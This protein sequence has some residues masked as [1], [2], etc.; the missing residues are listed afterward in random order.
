MIPREEARVKFT[1]VFKLRLSN[2]ND[3]AW[4]GA[5]NVCRHDL[6]PQLLLQKGQFLFFLKYAVL[7]RKR[8]KTNNRL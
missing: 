2:S 8:H 1:Q 7:W 5:I 6:R 3:A 4:T